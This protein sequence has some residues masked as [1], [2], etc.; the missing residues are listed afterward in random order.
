MSIW[1]T[2]YAVRDD[3]GL[4]STG[5]RGVFEGMADLSIAE[6]VPLWVL[7]DDD[8]EAP[9]YALNDS[10]DEVPLWVLP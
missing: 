7:D 8:N 1:S 3:S 5:L 6:P 2:L 9:L 10:D 4:E